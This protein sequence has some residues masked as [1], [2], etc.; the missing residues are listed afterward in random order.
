MPGP[1]VDA[2]PGGRAADGV[3]RPLVIGEVARGIGRRHRRLAEHVVGIAEAPRLQARG[4]WPAPRRWSGRRR[5]AR[6]ASASRDRRRA[7]IS[8]S[9]PRAISRV[10]RRAQSPASLLVATS[11]PVTS[12]PQVAALTNSDAAVPEMRV[13][14]A[15]RDLVADQA[16]RAWRGR[17]CAA[18]PRR[19]TSARR[20]PRSTASI[21]GSAPRRRRRAAWPAA[22]RPAAGGPAPRA[23]GRLPAAR[24]PAAAGGR[25]SASGRR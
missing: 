12:S 2:A 5:T 11:R 25:H 1:V 14:V 6:P 8:G 13:P 23:C 21:P 10:E 18:A 7:R 20:P 22:P 19:G 3:D 4:C 16:H 15:L 9:P 24:R 17:E